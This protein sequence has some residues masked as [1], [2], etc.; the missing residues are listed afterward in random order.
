M[1]LRLPC[2]STI[3]GTIASI[4]ILDLDHSYLRVIHLTSLGY[5]YVTFQLQ[6]RVRQFFI[7]YKLII[8]C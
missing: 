2:V 4:A 7:V 1:F 3:S 6:L 5:Q 8:I